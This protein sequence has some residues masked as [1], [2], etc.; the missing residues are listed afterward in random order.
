[1]LLVI[2]AT[3]QYLSANFPFSPKDALMSLTSIKSTTH[4]CLY[5]PTHHHHHHTQF[6]LT[7]MIIYTKFN[8]R[9]VL[10]SANLSWP[11]LLFFIITK[12][13]FVVQKSV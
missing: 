7:G 1:M 13:N 10:L 4:L 5:P 3:D 8:N 6:L 12:N 11:F 9:K 2:T